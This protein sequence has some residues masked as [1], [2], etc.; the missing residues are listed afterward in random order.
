MDPQV[1]PARKARKVLL[2][3]KVWQARPGQVVLWAC[4]VRPDHR[5]RK[6]RWVQSAHWVPLGRRVILVRQAL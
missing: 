3:C 6:G 2:E 4:K 5:G 1:L